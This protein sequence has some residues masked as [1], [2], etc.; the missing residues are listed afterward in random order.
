MKDAF[1]DPDWAKERP[2]PELGAFSLPR[3]FLKLR[4]QGG[5][6]VLR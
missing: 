1:L 3:S 5:M 4:R 2:L 6:K